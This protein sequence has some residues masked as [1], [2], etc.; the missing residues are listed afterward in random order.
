MMP[1]SIHARARTFKMYAR[2]ANVIKKKMSKIFY[3]SGWW[4]WWAPFIEVLRLQCR[5]ALSTRVNILIFGVRAH[6]RLV[7]LRFNARCISNSKKVYLSQRDTAAN[8]IIIFLNNHKYMVTCFFPFLFGNVAYLLS[9]Y[10]YFVAKFICKKKYL[11]K[12]KK[13]IY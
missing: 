4:W 10:I 7:I 9:L 2:K 13:N 8:T 6:A 1:F 3:N 11:R 12:S 5:N